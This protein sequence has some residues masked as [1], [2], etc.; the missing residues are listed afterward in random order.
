MFRIGKIVYGGTSLLSVNNLAQPRMVPQGNSIRF[1]STGEHGN[2]I[3]LIRCINGLNGCD[4]I[5]HRGVLV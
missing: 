4:D 2:K 1:F 3:N 5:A